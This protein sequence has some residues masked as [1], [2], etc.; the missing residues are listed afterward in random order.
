MADL[1]AIE[2]AKEIAGAFDGEVRTHD[3]STLLTLA[4]LDVAQEPA[5][6]GQE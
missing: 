6:P 3:Y 5:E 2:G 4:E 1:V